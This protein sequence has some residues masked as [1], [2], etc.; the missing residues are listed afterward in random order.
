MSRPRNQ[1]TKHR[2]CRS[3]PI[4]KI[5]RTNDSR[6]KPTKPNGKPAMHVHS[7][8][9]EMCKI[10]RQTLREVHP[11][12]NLILSFSMVSEALQEANSEMLIRPRKPRVV[13]LKGRAEIRKT[14]GPS[15][16]A[17]PVEVV[18]QIIEIRY[19]SYNWG[20]FTLRIGNGPG[21]QSR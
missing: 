8:W 11:T 13:K 19:N 4:L 7:N 20:F 1:H 2:N 12:R 18:I 10:Q 16:I 15:P 3:Q 5:A 17:S 14:T 6:F 21:E 9:H